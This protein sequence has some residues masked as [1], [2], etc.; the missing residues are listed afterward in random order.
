MVLYGKRCYLTDVVERWH[1]CLWRLLT[2][3]LLFQV[4]RITTVLK[5]DIDEVDGV[6]VLAAFSNVG[7]VGR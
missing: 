2:A 5:I 1:S 3:P 6:D 4:G 7:N